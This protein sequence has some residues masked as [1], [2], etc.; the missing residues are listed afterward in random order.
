ME[1]KYRGLPRLIC[2]F[3]LTGVGSRSF[4]Q[5]V[6]E[7]LGIRA[8]G[9]DVVEG[10]EGYQLREVAADYKPLFGDE[11]EDIGLE[12]AYFWKLNAE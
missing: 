6:K 9:R 5:T 10:G 11:S 12:D 2:F 7:F 3:Y 8:K 4:V 1:Q